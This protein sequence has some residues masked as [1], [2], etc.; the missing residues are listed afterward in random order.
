MTETTDPLNLAHRVHVH[1]S[2]DG[3]AASCVCGWRTVQPTREQRDTHITA[4][5]AD[6]RRAL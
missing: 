4:H 2:T 5:V 1:A 6:T 3:Y